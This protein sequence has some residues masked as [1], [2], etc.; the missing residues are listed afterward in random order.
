MN[1]KSLKQKITIGSANFTQK[2]GADQIKIKP[3]ELKKILNLALQNNINKIDTADSYVNGS[4]VF[5]KI[6]K[7]FK[8]ISKIKPNNKWVSLAFCRKKIKDHFKL[9]NDNRVHTLL[10]HDTDILFKTVGPKIFKNLITL[11]KKKYFKKIGISIYDTKNLSY[12][13]NQYDLDVV[14][15]PYNVLDKRII[16]SGWFKKLKDRGIEVHIRS[17]FLQGLLVNKLFYKKKYFKKWKNQ[18]YSWFQSLEKNNIS[19]IDYCLNDLLNYEF[20]QIIIGIKNYN[21]LKEIIN[22]KKISYKKKITVKINDLKL[23]DPRKWKINE[24]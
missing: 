19:P 7:K 5:K 23:I 6:N 8:F 12:L 3:N 9:F 16:Q 13:V 18:I 2:Y 11:K 1:K 14:Q 22:F 21:N 17:I 4:G 20:D 15:C 10:F 24:N